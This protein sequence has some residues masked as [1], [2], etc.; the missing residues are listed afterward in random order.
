MKL[1]K[2]PLLLLFIF[3]LM[4]VL[5]GGL[6]ITLAVLNRPTGAVPAEGA[7]FEVRRGE[8]SELV[9]LRLEHDGW[10]RSSLLL[11]MLS[12]VLGTETALKMGV[13]RIGADDSALDI[14]NAFVA[15]KQEMKRV[16][17]REGWT[18][19]QV[20][21]EYEAAGLVAAKDFLA[22]AR[23]PATARKY[24]ISGR[25]V[26]G[27]LFPETYYFTY[28]VSAEDVIAKM[29]GTFYDKLARIQPAY[30]DL[31]PVE[32][33][34]KVT[35][36]SIV[37]REYR[38]EDEAPVI[39]SVFYNRLAIRQKLESCATIAYVLTEQL[40]RSHPERLT[41]AD[42]AV[43]SPYNTYVQYGLPPGPIGNPGATALIAAFKPMKTDYRYFV[44]KDPVTGRHEFSETFKKHLSAK[45]LYIKSY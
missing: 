14:H 8:P 11:R 22:A 3:F 17:V 25:S 15:G 40:G 23:S 36:A 44:L 33:Q 7:L 20:A 30:K 4:F 16:T 21:R 28:G 29:V 27:F 12:K 19:G 45:E 31:D 38:R 37:E 1:L 34:R 6:T 35:M 32:L 43:E 24:G 10:V 26:E 13:Y 42:L 41:W 18:M 39:A 5:A 2:I 9:Y